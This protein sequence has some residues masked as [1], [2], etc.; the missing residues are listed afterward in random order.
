LDVGK[1]LVALLCDGITILLNGIHV[2]RLNVGGELLTQ[3]SQ[4]LDI[5][6][7]DGRLSRFALSW[8]LRSSIAACAAVIESWFPVCRASLRV[9]FADWSYEINSAYTA[10]RVSR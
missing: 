10:F 8:T 2:S 4:I 9:S 1:N 3:F 5:A 6:V 7:Y